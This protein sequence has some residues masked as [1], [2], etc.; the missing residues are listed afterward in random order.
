MTMSRSHQSSPW[1]A[2]PLSSLPP[3]ASLFIFVSLIPS[4]RPAL[5][6][7]FA[8][9]VSVISG[10]SQ[11]LR[12]DGTVSRSDGDQGQFVSR[13]PGSAAKAADPRVARHLDSG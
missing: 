6:A 13:A 1:P 9:F 8:T 3:M 4:Y 12:L 10:L 5:I 2:I 7:S 11:L